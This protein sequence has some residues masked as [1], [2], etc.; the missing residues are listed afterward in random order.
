MFLDGMGDQLSGLQEKDKAGCEDHAK[1]DPLDGVEEIAEQDVEETGL[2]E[3][4]EE[5]LGGA[6]GGEGE[7]ERV[8]RVVAAR[9]LAEEGKSDESCRDGGVE[10]DGMEGRGVWRDS[11]AP[12]EGGG[13]A[14]VAA[15]GEVAEREEGPDERGAG[16][17]GVQRGEKGEMAQAK[18]ED[19]DGCGEQKASGGERRHHQEKDW[20][21]EEA[22]QVGEDQKKAGEDEGRED[23]EE[24]GVPDR[25]GVQADGDGSAEAESERSHE[26][27]CG[28]DAEGGKEK[29]TGV[30]EVGVHVWVV[31]L[32]SA[33]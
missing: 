19:C 12:G 5:K 7:G 26:S 2:A 17:P 11:D 14:G 15:F 16:S 29:M 32:R 27:S 24:A 6:A 1:R 25:F 13:K 9:E 3:E 31:V 33:R 22:V 20:V 23:G 4:G 18:V 30:K 10:G 21:A 28:E 8:A